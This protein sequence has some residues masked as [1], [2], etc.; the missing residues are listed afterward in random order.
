MRDRINEGFAPES[1]QLSKSTFCFHVYY[2]TRRII[3]QMSVAL[4][5][6]ETWN[7]FN[8]AYN[9]TTYQTICNEFGADPQRSDLKTTSGTQWLANGRGSYFYRLGPHPQ[10]YLKQSAAAA[11]SF[12]DFMLDQTHGFTHHTHRR[13]NVQ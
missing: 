1:A 5:T 7:V 6:D 8:N 10:S 2:Q 4:P 9:H 3:H 12:V 11:N 13:R